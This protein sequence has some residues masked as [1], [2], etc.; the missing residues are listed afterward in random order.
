MCGPTLEFF[1]ISNKGQG[2]S[3]LRPCQ[4]INYG[5]TLGQI[6]RLVP[7]EDQQSL[8]RRSTHL[9]AVNKKNVAVNAFQSQRCCVEIRGSVLRHHNEVE[10]IL[11]R[12]R[13]DL[14]EVA[15]AVP[16]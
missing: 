2:S 14:F 5:R 15:R 9:V 3:R 1:G 4:Q 16:T 10:L 8:F 12:G 6:V 11:L 13:N 7:G